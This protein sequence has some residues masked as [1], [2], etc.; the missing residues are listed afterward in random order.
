[1][2]SQLD[3]EL[4]KAYRETDYIIS[5]DP[6]LM[7]KIGEQ[8][9]DAKILLASFGTNNG[10]FITAWNPHSTILKDQENDDRQ[11]AL[12]AEIEMRRLN[13]LVGY[14][15]RRDWREYSFF[16]LGIGH[17]DATALAHQ[18]EQNAYVWVGR[19]GLPELVTMI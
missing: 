18:F 13:Y 12:L 17:E 9:D 11:A 1:M 2:Q 10:A 19:D 14:G 7:L 5:D 8:S 16:I 6:P 3:P 4:L 15:E